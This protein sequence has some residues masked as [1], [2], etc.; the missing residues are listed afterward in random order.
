MEKRVRKNEYM[1]YTDGNTVRKVATAVP[2][3]VEPERK[4]E[5]KTETHKRTYKNPN[6]GLTINIPYVMFLFAAACAVVILCMK[7]I[8][9]NSEISKTNDSI[10][11]MEKSIETLRAQND[12]I[13]YEINSSID[14]DTIINTA[15]QELGMVQVTE[16]TIRFYRSTEGEYMRQFN[17][18]P[19]E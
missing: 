11:A 2:K 12:A 17:D 5:K 9:L 6:E 4:I 14:M 3:R 1:Y 16:D 10:I 8:N 18:V 19:A 7:Y 13:E 15:T